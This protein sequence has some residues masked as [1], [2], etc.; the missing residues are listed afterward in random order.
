[1]DRAGCADAWTGLPAAV[2][3]LIAPPFHGVLGGPA[4]P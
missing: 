2:E 4:V 3:G 1:M